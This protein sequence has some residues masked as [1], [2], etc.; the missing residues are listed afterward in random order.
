MNGGPTTRLFL[1]QQPSKVRKRKVLVNINGSSRGLDYDSFLR[2][3]VY[4][5][6]RRHSRYKHGYREGPRDSDYVVTQCRYSCKGDSC[7]RE[8]WK[9]RGLSFRTTRVLVE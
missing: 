8:P 2:L 4:P 1:C 6:V 9:D 7:L 5:E 3:G